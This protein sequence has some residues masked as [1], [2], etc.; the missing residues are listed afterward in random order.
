MQR[1]ELLAQARDPRPWD[2]V[3]IG[4]GATGLGSAVDA[5]ARGY[6]TLLIES[7]DFAK[8]TSSRATKL[9]H[10][11]VRYLAQGDIPLVRDAL[12][13]RGLMRQNAPHLVHSLALVVPAYNWWDQPFYGAGLIT[14]DLLAGSLSLG[15]SWPIS[16]A[17]M[18]KRVPTIEPKNL[19]GGVLYYDGQFD[20]ARYAVTLLRTFLSMGGVAL[21]YASAV[22]LTRSGERI[23]GVVVRDLETNQEFT[24]TAKAVVNA[25]GV[26]VDR[27]RALDEPQVKP[28]LSPSQGVHIVLDKAF[29]PGDT[30]VMIPR[31]DDGR[32]LFAIPWHGKA[33]IG[34]TDT[35]VK[36][37]DL[38]PRALPEE[39]EF[40]IDHTARYLTRDPNRSDVLSIY[41]GLRPLVKVGDGSNTKALSRDHTIA[42]SKAGLIT[43]TGG[44]WTTYR[45]M[46]E[47]TINRAAQ[48]GELPQR[49]SPTKTLKLHGW[50]D[51]ADTTALAVYGTDAE[52]IRRLAVEQPILARTLHERLPY[53]AAEVIW[54]ARNEL[55][56]TVED[57]LSRRTRALLLDARAASEAAPLVADL[58][59]AELGRDQA[60]RDQQVASFQALAA[61][62]ILA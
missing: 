53:R 6:R 42:I 51:V 14:Y 61:G 20:D 31:T 56:R 5:V 59:A 62:Y 36:Q 21:N 25:T 35:P 41:A 29:L 30:A 18:I 38:E 55:A 22:R 60:W 47:D 43:V 13:E 45:H 2:V 54:A 46:G 3:I 49:P 7:N 10:G 48:V 58:L 50:T 11:G 12:R 52:A 1:S 39:I 27:I 23:N 15:R 26:Y 32:V 37:A 9:A 4:G 8:G 44:K 16:R 24:A 28:M 34:T 57:V 33:L 19:K 17:E 40:L